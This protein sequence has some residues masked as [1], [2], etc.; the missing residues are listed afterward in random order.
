MQNSVSYDEAVFTSQAETSAAL[1][2]LM[3]KQPSCSRPYVT[4]HSANH[5]AHLSLFITDGVESATS[6]GIQLILNSSITFVGYI[7]YELCHDKVLSP[8]E[9]N[10]PFSAS[11][12]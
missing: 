10:H 8:L 7:A 11:G 1:L 5:N 12:Y 9:N 2:N 4:T 3:N 6:R